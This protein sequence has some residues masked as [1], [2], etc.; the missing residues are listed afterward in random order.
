M[1]LRSNKKTK[2]EVSL[3][4]PIGIDKEGNEISLMDILG[5]DSDAITDEIAL[6]FQKN[7]FMIK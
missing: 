4:N 6:K 7:D 1:N 5:T 2:I 3:H